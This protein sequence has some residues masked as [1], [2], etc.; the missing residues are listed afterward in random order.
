MMIGVLGHTFAL[1]RLKLGGHTGLLRALYMYLIKRLFV[2]WF[3]G[4]IV[5]IRVEL[6][7]NCFSVN[8]V[9]MSTQVFTNCFSVNIVDFD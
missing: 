1:V 4:N 2:T 5:H 9:H 6:F 7:E 3:S 8:I